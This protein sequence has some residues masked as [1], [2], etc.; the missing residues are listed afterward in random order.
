MKIEAKRRAVRWLAALAGLT[1][2]CALAAGPDLAGH[3]AGIWALPSTATTTR[4]L[5][6]HDPA[7]GHATGVYHIEVLERPRG[8]PAWQVDHVAGHM[9][10][11]EAAL[12]R[13][14]GKPLRRGAVY[15]ETFDSGLA[16]WRAENGGQ[17]GAVCATS[18]LDC[19]GRP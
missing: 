5:V 14:V 6:V 10:I 12:A 8:A 18:V 19:L 16:A 17:G 15:P 9:A 2:T 7:G 4:W 3:A 11:T 13:S 1:A